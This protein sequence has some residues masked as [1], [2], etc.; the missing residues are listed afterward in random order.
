MGRSGRPKPSTA[1]AFGHSSPP[2]RPRGIREYELGETENPF[3]VQFL[4][5]Q[6]LTQLS[7]EG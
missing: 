6:I 2:T 1:G 3:N 5:C 4:E 7:P